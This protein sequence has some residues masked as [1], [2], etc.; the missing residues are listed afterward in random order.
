MM[1]KKAVF[2]LMIAALGTIAAQAQDLTYGAMAGA[3]Y[4]SISVSTSGGEN[5]DNPNG[6]GFFLGGYAEYGLTEEIN[7]RPEV[8]LA[9]RRFRS[10]ETYS[11]FDIDEFGNTI[12]G[13]SEAKVRSRD[14]FLEI[15]L[16]FTYGLNESLEFM[17]GP[18]LGF[19]LGS[20]TKADV[21]TTIAG[22]TST[23]EFE[24]S[25]TTGRNGFEFGL[26]L[27]AQYKVDDTMA[28]GLRYTRVLTDAYDFSNQN[29]KY[30]LLRVTFSYA[31][32][33]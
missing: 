22:N 4:N 7:F 18:S 32:D 23:S 25:G 8:H 10:T 12:E 31:L 5:P 14:T 15:P 17:A 24:D 6:F 26:A 13:T 33:L 1:M 9:F 11:D 30:N 28:V 2:S 20:K 3:G 27:G 29:S 21:T 19:L 16:Y